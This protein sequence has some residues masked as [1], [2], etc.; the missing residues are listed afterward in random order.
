MSNNS[1]RQAFVII[2][3]IAIIILIPLFLDFLFKV[4]IRKKR[5][6]NVLRLVVQRARDQD[7]PL[8]IINDLHHGIIYDKTTL[9]YFTGD[10]VRIIDKLTKNSCVV[11]ISET[12]EY[13]N[14]LEEFMDKLTLVTGGD[15]YVICI[16]LNSPRLFWDYKIRHIMSKSYFEP[17]EVV[18]WVPPNGLQKKTQRF[19]YYL[20]QVIPYDVF[21]TSPITLDMVARVKKDEK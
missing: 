9:E 17:G 18:K 20:F 12:L 21:V 7:K 1:T 13:I 4:T 10:V 6:N 3:Y 8:I 15:L 11:L 19:Y 14:D 2:L 5:K 16:E